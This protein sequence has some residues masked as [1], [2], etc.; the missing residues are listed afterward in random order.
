M[1]HWIALLAIVSAGWL[2]VAVVG[3]WLI[4]RGLAVLARDEL[5]DDVPGDEAPPERTRLRRAA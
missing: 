4:G 5:E 2:V 1:P 3:G